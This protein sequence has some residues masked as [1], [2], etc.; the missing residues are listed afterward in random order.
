MHFLIAD[1]FTDALAR[2]PAAEQKAV[3]LSAYDLQLDPSSPGLQFHRVDRSKDPNFWSMR[4]SRDLRII[5]HKTADSVLLA[6]VD[7]H[8]K[9]YAWAERR[10]IEAHPKT[11]AV[12][13]VEVRERVEE[14]APQLFSSTPVAEPAPSAPAAP[15]PK[16]LFVGLSDEELL[17]VGTPSDWLAAVRAAT[18]DR[19]F[20]LAAHLPAEAAEALLAYAAEGALRR[21]EPVPAPT[22][23]FAHPDTRRRFRVV[24][25]Q[26]ELEAALDAPWDKWSIFLHPSQRNVVERR[27]DGPAR[28]AGSAGTGKTVVA[29]HR[30][31][32]LAR[33]EPLARVLLT[34]FSQPLADAL[35][36]KVDLLAGADRG[37]ASRITVAPWQGLADELHQLAFGRRPRIATEAQV[38]AVLK[39]AAEAIGVTDASDR[40]LIAEFTHVVDAWQVG[41]LKAYA[42][43]P[44]LGRKTR[45]GGRQRE[46]LWPIFAAARGELA[47]LG[48]TTWAAAFGELTSIWSVR[49]DK[50]FAHVVVDEAQDLGV[51]ELR[52][53]SVITPG[54]DDALF[55]A[56][57][58]GQRIFQPPFSWKA[59]GVDVRGRSTGLKVNYRT[60]HQIRE[61]ADRLLPGTVR[62][63]D[64]QEEGRRGTVSVFDGPAPEVEK[65]ANARNEQDHVANFL[66]GAIASGMTSDEI[67]VFVRARAQLQRARDAITSAGLPPLEAGDPPTPAGVLVSTM[68]LAKG[69]EFKAVAVMACDQEVIPDFARISAAADE[70]EL[71]EVYDTERQLF[72]VACTRA[73]DRLLV[74][75]VAPVSEFLDDLR[76]H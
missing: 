24:E 64:G 22:D 73:R 62:D 7:H 60:S 53:L 21:P 14:A 1:S 45:L 46:R 47:R 65:L 50:P 9:A 18:E 63:V 49:I 27:Y 51:P 31:V 11:G 71:D 30:A 52:L 38:A 41:G 36:R 48:L 29:V 74:T 35:R 37:A 70:A 23:P 33:A 20:D 58:L 66:R 17:S 61:A 40:F 25:N 6:Y 54:G 69:L 16:P 32:R 68:H 10:R 75:G 76:P 59:L 3:K 8:D 56:G 19:F 28:V 43:T 34:T 72:Y 15:A 2:L 13:I 55:F 57:D 44:R 67:G 4:V 12:Q 5:V 26:E 39:K 42:E